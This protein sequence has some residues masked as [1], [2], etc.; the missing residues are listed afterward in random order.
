MRISL[1]ILLQFLIFSVQAADDLSRLSWRKVATAMP[2]E[3]YS[4]PEARQI[5]DKLIDYQFENG[6]WPKNINFH[7]PLD[8]GRYEEMRKTGIGANI[9]NNATTTEMFFLAR[10]AATSNDEKYKQSFLKGLRYLFDAQ[11][12]NGGW[13]QFFPPRPNVPYSAH[14]TFNDNAYVNVMNVLQAIYR[15]QAPYSN[16]LLTDEIRK[17]AKTAFDKGVEC[18]LNT[19]IRK[20]G[21]LT[22]WCAQHDEHTLLPAKARAYE[23]ESYSGAESVGVVRLLMS[24][25]NPSPRIL[26]AIDSAIAWFKKHEIKDMAFTRIQDKDGKKKS[27]VS[28]APGNITWARFYDLDTEAPFFCDRDGI[29]KDSV[30]DI[31]SERRDGYGWYTDAPARLL[32]EYAVWKAGNTQSDR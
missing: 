26:T 13:P 19:Q 24:I 4:T 3:W 17:Q 8:E 32:E 23:L 22:V 2:S 21:E 7:L 25:E 16:L 15:N 30:A 6:G 20:N 5:A 18:I 9:D 29:K 11:Y 1:F 14:I 27:S 10:I 28:A 12:E 31:G